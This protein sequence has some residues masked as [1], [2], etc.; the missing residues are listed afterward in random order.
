MPDA[1]IAE[2]SFT[3]NQVTVGSDSSCD[4]QLSGLSPRHFR[5]YESTQG[6][7]LES[8][9]A[10]VSINQKTGSGFVRDQTYEPPVL[11]MDARKGSGISGLYTITAF[12]GD[13]MCGY[14]DWA[15]AD[16]S[17]TGRG[18]WWAERME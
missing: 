12:K 1:K 15:W 5:I 17:K 10:D 2:R 11:W 13:R 14:V 9:A 8:F 6:W 18:I 7:Y 4:L 3:K 16:R